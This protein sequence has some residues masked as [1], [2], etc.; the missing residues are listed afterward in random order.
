M[1]VYIS[2]DCVD[3]CIYAC[4]NFI[5]NS[6][7][8]DC[9]YVDKI[10]DTIRDVKQKYAVSPYNPGDVHNI[11]VEDLFLSIDDQSFFEQLLLEIRGATIQ[12]SS[13]KKN[14][15][16]TNKKKIEKEINFLENL[17]DSN[18]LPSTIEKLKQARSRLE[19]FRK[20]FINGLFAR[21]KL[22]WIE[23]GEKPT[24]YFLSL[25]KRNYVN[26]TVSKLVTDD[27]IVASQIDILNEIE[28]FYKSLY[29][30]YDDNLKEVELNS[31]ISFEYYSRLDKNSASELEGIISKEEALSALKLMKN[32]KSPGSDGFTTEFYK[33]FWRDLGVFLVRSLNYGF[34]IGNLSVTQK[35][36]VISIL[37][38]SDKAREYL[39]NW[40]PISLLNVSYKIASSCIANRI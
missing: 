39:K 9:V 19:A 33:F 40:R 35:Q 21:T 17:D 2:H 24:K 32:N 5:N 28:R 36:G 30:C 4:N 13:W 31:I 29:S 16:K 25:E 37:P 10:K 8:N 20:E 14:K 23:Q 22:K 18:S 1:C 27:G 26:K 12:Y 38:K 34:S 7:L 3:R 11:P 15:K 6:L